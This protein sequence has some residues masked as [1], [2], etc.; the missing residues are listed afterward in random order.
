MRYV[1]D[2]DWAGEPG[3]IAALAALYDPGTTAL[4]LR[5]GVDRGWRCWEAA[6]GSGTIARWL[7]DRVGSAGRVLVTDLDTRYVASLSDD[8]LEVLRHDVRA[9][10]PALEAF[11]LVHARALLEHLREPARALRGMTRALRPGAWLVAEDVVFPP[12]VT[13]PA[14]PL[15][16]R[17]DAAWRQ[18]LRDGGVDPDYGVKLPAALERAGLVEVRCEARVPV[19]RLGTPD[20]ELLALSLEQLRP[21]LEGRGLVT[22]GEIDETLR[23]LRT[24][25]GTALSAIMVAAWGRRPA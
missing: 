16:A 4:L 24:R 7:A 22:A 23:A 8:R 15:L 13:D 18:A 19:L 3:R 14:L 9:E 25:E 10:P 21:R 6:A 20:V 17:L 2:H 1:Y 11:D 12:R 5:L